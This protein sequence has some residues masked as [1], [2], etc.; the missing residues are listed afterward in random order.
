MQFLT[1]IHLKIG[2]KPMIS[3]DNKGRHSINF[4]RFI[5]KLLLLIVWRSMVLQEQRILGLR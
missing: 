2:R 3:F 4:S 5:L 1:K